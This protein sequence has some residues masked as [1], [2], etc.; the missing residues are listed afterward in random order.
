MET[1]NSRITALR[2]HLGLNQTKFAQKIGVTSQHI[3][4]FEAGKAKLSETSI[5]LICL[6]FG[7]R[8]EWLREGKGDMMD[9]EAMLS[10]WEKRLLELF[11]KLSPSAQKDFI[12][13]VEKLVALATNE[14]GLRG[15][16]PEAPKQA[17]GST[18]QPPEAPQEAKGQESTDDGKGERRAD[19]SAKPV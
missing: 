13:Y 17:P 1:I 9:E 16:S 3:S 14:A 10:E 19:T 6:T 15:G 11:R 8:G 18:T 4:M 2:K 12:E 5:N 7:V